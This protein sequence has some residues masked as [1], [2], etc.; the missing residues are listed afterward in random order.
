MTAKLWPFVLFFVLI[1]AMVLAA[2][3][4]QS[5]KTVSGYLVVSACGTLGTP[6]VAGQYAPATVDTTGKFCVSQ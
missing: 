5:V 2:T 6:Y 3:P 1:A 4:T